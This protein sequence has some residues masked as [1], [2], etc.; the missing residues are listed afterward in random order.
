M[1]LFNHKFKFCEEKERE[2]PLPQLL[3][4]YLG[5]SSVLD[6]LPDCCQCW[7]ERYLIFTT[8]KELAV[9]FWRPPLFLMLTVFPIQRLPR[10]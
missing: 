4:A 7:T 9:S 3:M 8:F 2:P 1:V 5:K 6:S 10:R